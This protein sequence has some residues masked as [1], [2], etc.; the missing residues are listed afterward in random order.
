M[1]SPLQTTRSVRCNC[2]KVSFTVT[3]TDKLAVHCYC[4]NCQRT[5]GSAFAHNHRF[6]DARIEFERGEEFVR[7]YADG[8]TASERVMLRHFC[9][10]CVSVVVL[11]V[12]SGD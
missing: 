10:N 9:G 5:T 6:S 1:S 7:Q 12:R 2:G 3:G 11:A 4:V 8:D